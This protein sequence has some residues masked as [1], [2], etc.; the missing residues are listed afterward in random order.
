MEMHSSDATAEEI[1]QF[2]YE[3]NKEDYIQYYRQQGWKKSGLKR[4]LINGLV[5]ASDPVD[6]LELIKNDSKLK[7]TKDEWEYARKTAFECLKERM[8]EKYAVTKEE[9]ESDEMKEYFE[10]IGFA[11]FV[12]NKH[13]STGN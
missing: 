6:S 12:K 2:E 9:L 7:L 3:L 13:E 11:D 5:H 4:F 8:I 1:R 10:S